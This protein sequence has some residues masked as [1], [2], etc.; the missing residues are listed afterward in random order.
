MML[1]Q[2]KT[3]KN[4][5]PHPNHIL[6]DSGFPIL[7]GFEKAYIKRHPPSDVKAF[8]FM[9]RYCKAKKNQ[10]LRG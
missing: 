6:G 5:T 2:A 8:F 4:N 9:E 7:S 1:S 3:Q 10:P